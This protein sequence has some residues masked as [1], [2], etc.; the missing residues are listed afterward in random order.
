LSGS[1][2]FASQP[3]WLIFIAAFAFQTYIE[4]TTALLSARLWRCIV[5][6]PAIFIIIGC[7]ASA[8]APLLFATAA[9]FAALFLLLRFRLSIAEGS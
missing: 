9:A 7:H 8:M 4:I 5:I 2:I 6:T 3:G 1:A